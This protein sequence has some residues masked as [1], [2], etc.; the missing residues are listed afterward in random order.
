[1]TVI[2]GLMLDTASPPS[3]AQWVADL[4]AA[5][6][7]VGAVY[8]WGGGGVHY[9]AQHVAAAR[10]AGRRVLPIPVPGPSPPALATI[11]AACAALGIVGG[12]ISF[13]VATGDNTFSDWALLAAWI[14]QQLGPAWQGGPY[15]QRLVR[16]SCPQGWW[17]VAG[18]TKALPAG[19]SASQYGQFTGPSGVVYDISTIDLSLW[20]S[21]STGD[22]AMFYDSVHGLWW[23]PWVG[24]DSEVYYRKAATVAGL[25]TAPLAQPTGGAPGTKKVLG[26][27]VD[28]S[29]NVAFALHGGNDTVWY[30]STPDVG[31][32]WVVGNDAAATLVPPA[33]MA[34]VQA[35]I[36]AALAALPAPLT[37]AQVQAAI[38]T[39]I[40]LIPA[41]GV[42]AAHTHG[43]TIDGVPVA[44]G[45]AQ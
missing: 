18:G 40:A 25:Y 37:L 45:P 8:P 32:T 36:A 16:P 39:A 43:L 1:M 44:T 13:D 30:I 10:A 33:D 11:L 3:P 14:T 4:N 20:S 6:A 15:C 27:G 41:S 38:A 21:A 31:V 5:N 2:L 9:S 34:Q 23:S 12:P 7:Q 19:A 26:G 35:A 29:G 17:F 24:A 42:P 28:A 22:S